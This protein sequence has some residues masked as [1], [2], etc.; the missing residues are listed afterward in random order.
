VSTVVIFAI[1]RN[2][3]PWAF[4]WALAGS[5]Y[6]GC[7][8]L[9]WGRSQVVNVPLWRHA[10][11]LFAWPGMDAAAFLNGPS[12]TQP[13]VGEWAFAAGK[14]GLG[15]ILFFKAAAFPPSERPYVVGWI[16]MIGTVLT[17]HFGLFH[18]M[19]CAWRRIGVDA[20]PLMDWPLA[21]VSVSEFWGRR[22][23]TA[24]RDLTYRFLFRPLAVRVG[25][26]GAVFGGFLFSGVVHDAVISLPA[27]GGYG[28][29][30]LFFSL[31]AGAILLERSAFGR[32]AGLGRGST[33]RLF[34]L[35]V[36]LIPLYLLFHP[37]FVERVIVPM[38]RAFGAL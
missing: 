5:I 6:V 19:S 10:G 17:L 25:A 15:L 9:T 32:R 2:W 13:T 12:T 26:P 38:M 23:N 14:S 18:L 3:P 37:P 21:S 7:K 4:M 33:G 36:L 31:Q 11:Y 1:P 27:Q 22:W 29:P 30:T 34:T 16:G 24:F 8:W 35:A 20:P 28:G